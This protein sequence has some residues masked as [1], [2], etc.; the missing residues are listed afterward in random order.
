MADIGNTSVISPTDS[1]NGSGTMPSWL[2][3]AAPSTLDDAGRALQ[4]AIARE[5]QNRSFSVTSTGSAD[6]YVVAYTVAPAAYRT[7]QVY[8]FITNFGNTGTATVN[9]NTLGAKT[10]KKDVA[11][12]L[13]ELSSG[14]MGSGQFV[15]LAY[16]GT[17]MIWINW[18]GSA[19]SAA[20]TSAA[21]ISELLTTTELLT[22]TDTTRTA[23]A[24]SIAALWEAGSDITDGAAITIGEGGYFNLITSTT[25]ITSF[26]VTTTKAGRTFRC[27][28]N[29]ARTLTHNA[30]SLIL[31]GGANITTAQGDIAQ[32]RDLGSGNV[33]CEW[34][35]KAS[36]EPIVSVDGLAL[37]TSG[38]FTAVTT[39]DLT[40]LSGYRYVKFVIKGSRPATDA[41]AARVYFSSDA[42]STWTAANVSTSSILIRTG[43]STDA[44]AVEDVDY[45][46][47]NND[48]TDTGGSIGNAA[49]EGIWGT[50]EIDGFN[51][52]AQ[53]HMKSSVTVMDP[54]TNIYSYI[55]SGFDDT[56]TALNAI[57][58]QYDSGDIAAVGTYELWGA[59]G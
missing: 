16:N 32:F 45:Y 58:F 37:V 43:I 4:G 15:S 13:T 9:I 24:D 6:A 57:R 11:G 55:G 39:L 54:S 56:T 40:G 12:T 5:W 18:Q 3:S 35:T 44:V 14:D 25:A 17:D 21:G 22:G 48:D 30:T 42:G 50:L 2:G 1:S 20:T 19:A 41:V 26:V 46:P 52:A 59:A 7:G 23:T 49:G 10:I 53:K 51:Q 8:S 47:L 34:Y 36:G 29:T 31:P 28:F 27:R 38:S 33:V